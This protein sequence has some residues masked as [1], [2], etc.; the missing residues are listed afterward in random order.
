MLCI[1]D[2]G[3]TFHFLLRPGLSSIGTSIIC[4]NAASVVLVDRILACMLLLEPIVL[5]LGMLVY[6]RLAINF[7]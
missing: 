3:V 7:S 2:A 1:T 4:L 5:S 6:N